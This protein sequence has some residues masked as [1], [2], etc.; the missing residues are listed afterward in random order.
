MAYNKQKSYTKY[1]DKHIHAY[2]QTYMAPKLV[3][4]ISTVISSSPVM[5][6]FK[7]PLEKHNWFATAGKGPSHKVQ[8]VVLWF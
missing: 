2:K 5:T 7:G 4:V 6:L 1:P 3:T 8:P